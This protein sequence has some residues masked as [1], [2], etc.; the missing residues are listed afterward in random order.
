MNVRI[1]RSSSQA[2]AFLLAALAL[3]PACAREVGP[4]VDHDDWTLVEEADDP[5]DDRPADFDCEPAGYG[6]EPLGGTYTFEIDTGLCAYATARTTT[7]LPIVGGD[8]VR[9]RQW[10]TDLTA[11]EPAEAHLALTIGGEPFLDEAVP[12]PRAA[13]MIEVDTEATRRFPAG[14]EVFFHLHNHGSNTWNLVDV[15]VRPPGE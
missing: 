1:V 11:P 3:L 14:T 6:G 12:I 2:P 5:F 10:H 4:L 8:T 15:E 9:V 13:E 7:L